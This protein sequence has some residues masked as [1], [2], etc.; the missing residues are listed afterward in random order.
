MERKRNIAVEWYS[1][2][3]NV[4]CDVFEK[5]EQENDSDAK[6]KKKIWQRQPSDAN[7]ANDTPNIAINDITGNPKNGGKMAVMHNGKIFEKVGV[8]FSEVCGEL[9]AQFAKEIYGTNDGKNNAFWASGVSVVAHMKSPFIPAIHM[10]TRMINTSKL[11]F[12]GGMDLTPTFENKEDTKLFHNNLKNI[13]DKFDKNY[14]QKFKKNC[15]EYFYLAHRNEARGIGGIF[16]DQLNTNNWDDDFQFNKAVGITF[17][18]TFVKIIKNNLQKYTSWTTEEKNAQ[19]IKRGRYVE[20]NLLYDRGTRFGLMTGGNIEA[21]L[22]S[23]PPEAK[24]T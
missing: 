8:N 7:I 16:Y 22:M 1:L 4:I 14:Y 11:W 15:D 6:F 18:E 13:C 23:L 24:W 3:Q 19:L 20:F 9:P 10:N 21:I 17:Y 2:L 12:G 5:I